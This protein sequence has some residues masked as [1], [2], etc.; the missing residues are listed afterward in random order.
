MKVVVFG[1]GGREHALVRAIKNSPR[2]SEVHAIPGNDGMA[3]EALCHAID[4]KDFAAVGS[5]LKRFKFDLAV[6]GPEAL[7]DVGLVD[8]LREQGLLVVGPSQQAAKLESSKIFAKKFMLD[9]GV[10]TAKFRV[11]DSVDS[12]MKE[13]TAFK[14]PFV[15]KVDGLAAG[16]GVFIC[17]DA[18]ELK[19]SAEEVF[20]AKKF[21][22][23]GREALL[24]E[25]QEGYE[26][27][28]LVLTNG[29]D[30]E[31]LPLMQD[32]KRLSDGDL[33]PNTGG[34]GVVGPLPIDE[35]LRLEIRE[36]IVA[37]SVR[38]LERMGLD[39]KGVLFIGIMVTSRGPSVLEYNV[40]FGD[41]EAQAILPLLSGDWAEVFLNLAKGELRT[42]SW[43]PLYAACVVMA[44]PG[45]PDA[46]KK[47][48]RIEGNLA[49]ETP[50]SYFLHA[51]TKYTNS[52]WV[53]QGGRVIN[54]VGIGT[55]LREAMDKAYTQA[56]E[57]SWVGMQLRKDIGASLLKRFS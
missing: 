43:K 52:T 11:V 53:T 4:P 45:Y 47:D 9:S 54:S 41:P 12:L 39:F 42:L 44:A 23:A 7:L 48:V 38:G 46:P 51:G 33:G 56:R 17:K 27:S 6:V 15:L 37:P 26:L 22:S 3:Q 29:K 35:A 16:K 10:P 49:L 57:I 36:K 21:G 25:F 55:S 28:C 40:R 19:T 30:F 31:I 32:H 20:G 34:M 8:F 1:N 13:S 50:S 24:E 18:N 5:T 14:P 2:V